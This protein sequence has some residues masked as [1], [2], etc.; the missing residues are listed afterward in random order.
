MQLW[1]NKE[2]LI[3]AT[4]DLVDPQSIRRSMITNIADDWLHPD[5]ML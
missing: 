3:S 4:T 1:M 5:Y 2:P